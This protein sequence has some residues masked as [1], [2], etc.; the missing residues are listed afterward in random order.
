MICIINLNVIQ[1]HNPQWVSF[2]QI[3]VFTEFALC[4]GIG[5]YS[6]RKIVKLE[7]TKTPYTS[8]CFQIG[9]KNQIW[10]FS[11]ELN[12]WPYSIYLI[13]Y[14]HLLQTV[15]CIGLNIHTH[16]HFRGKLIAA[17]LHHIQL[18]HI[19]VPHSSIPATAADTSVAQMPRT[20]RFHDQ[21]LLF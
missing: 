15:V 6:S 2:Q 10:L 18:Q 17:L 16:C 9:I 20:S 12:F 13:I 21:L 4:P 5:P 11:G 7:H 14:L 3:R 19:Q 1:K 8:V